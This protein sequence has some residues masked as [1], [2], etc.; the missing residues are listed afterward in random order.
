MVLLVV[1]VV[2]T[3][4]VQVGL[5]LVETEFLSNTQQ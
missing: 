1:T 4:V 2:E 3:L 5:E